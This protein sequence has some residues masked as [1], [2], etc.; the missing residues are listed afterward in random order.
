MEM[1]ASFLLHFLGGL[2]HWGGAIC[3][4]IANR[5]DNTFDHEYLTAI[6]GATKTALLALAVLSAQRDL[7]LRDE[8]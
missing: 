3:P 2:G 5:R 6:E 1:E 7:A 4:V 8:K